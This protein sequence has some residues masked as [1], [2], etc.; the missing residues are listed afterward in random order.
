MIDVLVKRDFLKEKKVLLQFLPSNLSKHILDKE[1][2]EYQTKRLKVGYL[3]DITHTLL[4]KYYT[5]SKN[6]IK[7]NFFN[8]S[9]TILQKKYGK[10]YAFYINYLLDINVITMP[11]DYLV[12]KK[13]KTY[14]LSEQTLASDISRY[15]NT[16]AVLIKKH[17]QT[18]LDNE[19]KSTN[20]SP[21]ESDLRKRL[22][23]DL[24]SISIDMPKSISIL[25]QITDSESKSK[26]AY[27][28][29][30]IKIGDIFYNFDNFGRMHTNFTIL[31]S[32]I[33][34]QC[35]S[36]DNEDIEELDIRNSQPLFLALI[37][38]KNINKLDKSEY[39]FFRQSVTKGKIYEY[40]MDECSIKNK[41]EVKELMY[42]VLFGRNN[43]NKENKIFKSLFPTIYKFIRDYKKNKGDYRTMAYLLQR[44]ESNFLFN[45]FVKS[46]YEEIEGIK[47]FTIHDSV[48]YPIRYSEQVNKIFQREIKKII[49]DIE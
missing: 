46:L 37:L 36:I 29:E 38:S 31:K 12:G 10:F 6:D 11:S 9:S 7:I 19:I 34:K 43:P 40:F 17:K 23:S 42:K 8:L 27:S 2:I 49:R 24:N 44:S 21:I 15:R 41:K 20:Y 33:R 14:S 35:L 30:S 22:I 3:I 39:E 4:I 45:K 48:S 25:N 16:D 28:V 1:I 32:D 26:N 13:A 47:L 18:L 5:F